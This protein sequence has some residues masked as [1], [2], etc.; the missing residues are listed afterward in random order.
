[1]EFNHGATVVTENL[2]ERKNFDG[3]AR[4]RAQNSECTGIDSAEFGSMIV[5]LAVIIVA[6]LS[7]ALIGSQLERA[8][9]GFEDQTGFHFV[10]RDTDAGGTARI[11]V[12]GATALVGRD[13]P[14]AAV[15]LT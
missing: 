9:E 11:G 14:A 13:E 8:P 4:S 10:I 12:S 15:S 2:T 3:S 1:V 5:A 6:L 7:A